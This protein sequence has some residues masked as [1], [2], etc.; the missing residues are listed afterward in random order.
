MR[1]ATVVQRIGF[2]VGGDEIPAG[3]PAADLV[4]RGELAGERIGLVEGGGRGRDEAEML[5]HRRQRRQDRHGLELHHLAHAAARVGVARQVD[6]GR[7]GQEQKVELAA[8]GR[9]RHL[10]GLGEARA[11]F[12]VRPRMA[13]GGD[14][15]TGLVHEGPEMHHSTLLRLRHASPSTETR[16]V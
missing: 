11:R 2:V 1:L 12:G 5:G 10:D 8:L 7:I 3:A 16:T 9:L 15:L 13:P 6:G 4:E 14:M